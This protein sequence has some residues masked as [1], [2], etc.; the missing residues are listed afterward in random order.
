MDLS[1]CRSRYPSRMLG[2]QHDRGGK[3][4]RP[5]SRSRPWCYSQTG[6]T[7]VAAAD[8]C[9]PLAGER[10]NFLLTTARPLWLWLRHQPTLMPGAAQILGL[11]EFH[12]DGILGYPS[13]AGRTLA[14]G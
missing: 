5:R 10:S 4:F 11:G 9:V 13:G 2:T 1:S 6:M 14:P 12:T 8:C 7:D 3:R